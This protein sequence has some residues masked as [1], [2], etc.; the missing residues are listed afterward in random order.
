MEDNRINNYE[1]AAK[2]IMNADVIL[3]G[4]GAGMGVGSGLGTFRGQA[5]GVWPPLTR[6]GLQFQEMSCPDRFEE[7]DHIGGPRL[8]WA[9]W[10]WRHD[11]YTQN[12]PHQGYQILKKWSDEKPST[13]VY[14]SNIDGH[15]ERAGFEEKVTECHGTIQ[16]LQCLGND[17]KCPQY[18]KMWEVDTECLSKLEIDPANDHVVGTLPSCPG[19]GGVARPTVLMFGDGSVAYSRI[20]HQEEL[21]YKWTNEQALKQHKNGG[22]FKGD[23]AEKNYRVVVIEIGAGVAIPTVRHQCERISVKFDCPLIRIN[24]ES[25]D[26]KKAANDVQHISITDSGEVALKKI[27]DLI[28]EMRK[29]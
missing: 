20:Q 29:K 9:F 4:A 8:A 1:L 15:F 24:P 21:Y 3:I 11:A 7:D 17:N 14:T 22:A 5:A 10:K 19:C 25:P 12:E 23:P 2:Y 26:I 6:L 28:I 18:E 16:F 13:F 27:D